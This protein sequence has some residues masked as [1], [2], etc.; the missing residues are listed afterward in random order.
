MRERSPLV[1]AA[2]VLAACTSGALAEPAPPAPAAAAARPAD[3]DPLHAARTHLQH[4]VF[5]I[6]ENRTF[7]TLFGRLPG[8]DG[9]RRGR[10]CNGHTVRLHVAVDRQPDVEH[11]F[12]PAARAVNGGKMNCFDKLWNGTHLQSYVQ[13]R[14]DQIPNYWKLATHFTLADRF[15]SSVY[16]PTGIEHLWTVAG[17]SDRFVDHEYPGQWGSGEPREYCDDPVERAFA[18][19]KLAGQE[20]EAAMR[21]EESVWTVDRIQRFWIQRWPCTDILVLPDLLRWKGIS[22]RYYWGGNN[23]VQ[24]L[25]MI[26]HIRRGPMWNN[27]VPESTFI[28]DALAG[29]LPAVSWVTPPVGLSDH[30]PASICAG[31]NWTVRLLDA[32]Q[33]SPQWGRTAVILTWDDFGGFYDHVAPPHVDLFGLG[34]R[35]PA[36]VISPWAKPGFVDH[37]TLEFSSVLKLIERLHDLPSMGSRDEQAADMLEAFDFSHPTSRVPLSQR[38]CPSG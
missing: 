26:R 31:E 22:W 11:H 28:G 35:V 19:R 18:F 24:P 5:V 13:Y 17:Q 29:R 3:P 9:A 20:R 2:L 37:T 34:P 8:A 21:L 25:R 14:R 36:I 30:P 32:I 7:D 23:W 6:K 33:R 4:I 15:F 10:I 38:S 12:I 27:V 16:G 1:V